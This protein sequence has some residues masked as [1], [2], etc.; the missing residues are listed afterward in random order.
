[1]KRKSYLTFLRIR[2][3]V[4]FLSEKVTFVSLLPNVEY[5]FIAKATS[6]IKHLGAVLNF[7]ASILNLS[8]RWYRRM[9]CS[10]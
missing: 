2:F 3:S 9:R 1:M 6:V 10:F 7:E 4:K 8:Y 5:D